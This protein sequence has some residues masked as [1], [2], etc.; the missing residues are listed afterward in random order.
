MDVS[1]NIST[2]PSGFLNFHIG[3]ASE[4]NGFPDIMDF[5]STHGQRMK[6]L[7]HPHLFNG[8]EFYLVLKSTSKSGVTDIKVRLLLV[9][10][11]FD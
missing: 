10:H 2:G 1:W 3:I 5:V 4:K 11:Q 7:Y 6:R 8:E 9:M